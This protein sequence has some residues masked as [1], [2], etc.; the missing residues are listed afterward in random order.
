M[1]NPEEVLIGKKSKN[2]N[3]DKN[4][5]AA[6]PIFVP[7]YTSSKIIAEAVLI[8]GQPKCIY[9]NHIHSHPRSK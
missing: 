6:N 3:N 4:G 9:P 8:S 5:I 7:R 1:G 2:N